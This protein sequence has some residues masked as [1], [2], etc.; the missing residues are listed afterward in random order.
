MNPALGAVAAAVLAGA[1]F[2]V[3]VRDGR[4][5][6]V[7]L[8]VTLVFAPLL[9]DPLDTPLALAARLAGGVLAAY[10]LWIA[11]RDGG[12]TGGS[13]IG[14]PSEALL[15][16]AAFIVGYGTHGL[17]A[18]ALGPAEAQA[19]GFGLAALAVVP[20]ATGRDVLRIGIGLFVLLQAALLIRVG[21]DG[22]PSELEQLVTAALLAALGGSIAALGYAA[23]SDGPGGFDLATES[24]FR[25]RRPQDARREGPRPPDATP[26]PGR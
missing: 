22:N 9:A 18:P 25:F 14:W 26:T 16:A 15:A 17:G 2:A 6:V 7:G 3:S 5:V 8:A 13:R 12:T 21:L 1:V 20:V 11:V 4:I 24:R 19:A 23:R 10:L